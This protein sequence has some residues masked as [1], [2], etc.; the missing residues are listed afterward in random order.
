MNAEAIE[1]IERI[2]QQPVAAASEV[3]DCSYEDIPF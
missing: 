3:A 1:I 2:S